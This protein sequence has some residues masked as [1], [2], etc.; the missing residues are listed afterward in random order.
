MA[1]E[2]LSDLHVVFRIEDMLQS[3]YAY[4][5]HSLKRH[6]EFVK[7]AEVMATMGLKILKNNNTRWLS[8]LSLAVRVMNENITSLVKMESGLSQAIHCQ[9]KL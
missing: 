8:M 2:T 4:F 9:E 5:S 7:L 6:L 3:L 1:Q